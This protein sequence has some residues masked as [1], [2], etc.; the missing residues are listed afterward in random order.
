MRRLKPPLLPP[1]THQ[2]YE[3]N[4]QIFQEIFR[5]LLCEQK[6]LP[7][8]DP[9]TPNPNGIPPVGIDPPAQVID[10]GVTL[11][12]CF[13]RHGCARISPLGSRMGCSVRRPPGQETWRAVAGSS[14]AN[15]AQALSC[16]Q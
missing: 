6:T 7:R 1:A 3:D 10:P 15:T 13:S 5:N 9:R 8:C 2:L 12:A 11:T 16:D 14:V 4:R